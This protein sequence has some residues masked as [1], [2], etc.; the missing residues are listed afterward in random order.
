MAS[1]VIAGRAYGFRSSRSATSTGPSNTRDKVF[2]RNILVDGHRRF[3]IDLDHDVGVAVLPRNA[4]S[5]PR[6]RAMM[7]SRLIPRLQHNG[8]D[9]AAARSKGRIQRRCKLI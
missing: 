6:N 3:R 7:S 1:V 4:A 9:L 5:F 8:S 2:D